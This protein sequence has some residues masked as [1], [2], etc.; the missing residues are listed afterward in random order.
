[1][2][3]KKPYMRVLSFTPDLL[4]LRRDATWTS[5]VMLYIGAA[6]GVYFSFWVESYYF[7]ASVVLLGFCCGYTVFDSFDEVL[8]EKKHN[9]I[10]IYH[11]TLFSYLLGGNL[12]YM[13]ASM[14]EVESVTLEE[15]KSRYSGTGYIIR[16]NLQNGY[17]LPLTKYGIHCNQEEV[18]KLALS[19]EKW[20]GLNE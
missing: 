2:S 19:I 11:D 7:K 14:N 5:W 4:Q 18:K 16:L 9:K 3:S 15:D 13:A 10:R 20:L 17:P 8:L 1:M 12:D 6:I